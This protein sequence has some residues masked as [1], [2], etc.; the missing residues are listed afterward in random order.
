MFRSV[1]AFEFT[2][3]T[4]VGT[5]RCCLAMVISMP[6]SRRLFLFDRTLQKHYIPFIV[7]SLFS[8]PLVASTTNAQ[9]FLHSGSRQTVFPRQRIAARI[10]RIVNVLPGQCL[11]L[12]NRSYRR[13]ALVGLQ[14]LHCLRNKHRCGNG[15]VSSGW[16]VL[17]PLETVDALSS[18]LKYVGRPCVIL[19]FPVAV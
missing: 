10:F 18:I 17:V 6:G 4:Y 3:L 9:K 5:G 1:L 15:E 12:E 8:F 11:P 13:L 19:A 16:L 14:R 2:L 7:G